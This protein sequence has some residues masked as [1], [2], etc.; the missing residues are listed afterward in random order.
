MEKLN[1]AI[2]GK[3]GEAFNHRLEQ[4]TLTC[5]HCGY[6]YNPCAIADE[7][8]E[9]MPPRTY[10]HQV[11][12]TIWGFIEQHLDNYHTN[13]WVTEHNDL[14][15]WLT[16]PESREKHQKLVDD[17]Y[18][19]ESADGLTEEV[20]IV[21]ARMEVI[22]KALLYQA[23]RDYML[24]RESIFAEII[25]TT[26]DIKMIREKWDEERSKAEGEHIARKLEES[27]IQHGWDYLQL[28]LPDK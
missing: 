17:L 27:S 11:E 25:W 7:P 16:E 6:F 24:N 9:E 13:G 1:R 5:P 10:E 21:E 3:C 15:Q 4:D 19:D 28:E 12:P 23:V 20:D 26:S 22:E 14:H 2:C 18:D 8:K